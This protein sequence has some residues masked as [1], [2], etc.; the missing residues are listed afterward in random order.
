MAS[1]AAQ[2]L[3]AIDFGTTYSGYAYSYK[4]D[5]SKV[6]VNSSWPDGR[7]YWKVPTT[8]LF[9]ETKKFI[10]FGS[11]AENKFSRLAMRGKERECYYFSC[12]KMMLHEEE[13]GLY[14]SIP[15]EEIISLHR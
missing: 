7:N 6:Y 2:I 11:E 13:V 8:I 4:H 15:Y 14:H 5:Q 3:A 1:S 12:F 9:D 10:A